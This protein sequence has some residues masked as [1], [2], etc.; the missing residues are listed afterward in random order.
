LAAGFHHRK[1]VEPIRP[2][3]EPDADPQ[4]PTDSVEDP[5]PKPEPT[6]KAEPPIRVIGHTRKWYDDKPSFSDM[7]F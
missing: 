3:E 7:K 4:E 5:S 6:P 1:K 2:P